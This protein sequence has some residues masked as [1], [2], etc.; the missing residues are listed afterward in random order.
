MVEDA[1]RGQITGIYSLVA[2]RPTARRCSRRSPPS[3][4]PSSASSPRCACLY[5]NAAVVMTAKII[6]LYLSSR[7][8]RQGRDPHGRHPRAERVAP[9]WPATAAR[10]GCCCARAVRSSRWPSPPST[11]AVTLV[12]ATFWQVVVSQHLHVPD[13]LLPFFPMVRSMLSVLFF[14]TLIRS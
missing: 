9:A 14:F 3:W 11:A 1:E 6:W 13:A 12:N 2:S 10:S 8:T 7:E 4:S 5:I